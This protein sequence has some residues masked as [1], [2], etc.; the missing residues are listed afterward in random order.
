M[1]IAIVGS[2]ISGMTVAYLLDKDHDIVLYEANDYIGGHS[3]TVP[4]VVEGQS[5]PVDT[6]FMVFNTNTY[7]GLIRLL[8]RLNVKYQPTSMSFSMS[9]ERTGIEYCATSLNTIFAQR[10]NLFRPSFYRMFA[11]IFRFKRESENVLKE[12][13]YETSLMEYL[14]EHNYSRTFIDHF[15]IPMGAAIWSADPRNFGKISARLFIQFLTNHGILKA[16]DQP[17]W[18]TIPGGSQKYVE[19]LTASFR[20]RIRLSTPVTSIQRHPDHVDISDGTGHTE[21]FDHVVLAVHSDEVPG[22]LHD[23]SD[24]ERD[25]L[26]AIP[27]S[28]NRTTLHTDARLM[29][30]SRRAWASWNYRVPEE[31]SGSVLVTYNM[32]RLQHL[33]PPATLCV[34]LNG[35]DR[36][37]PSQVLFDT[38]YAHPLFSASSAKA[39]KRWEEINGQNRTSYCGAYWRYGFHEDGLQSALWVCRCF[40]RELE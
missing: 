37:D 10:R 12:E 29:P 18:L 21:Q 9:C 24:R 22:I 23:M 17:Q 36:L 30:Q 19:A 13:D 35:D 28:R 5:Y 2:G 39:Q 20:E 3:H 7:P 26:G 4:A 14:V 31:E 16:R 32:N 27:Y 8:D 6:G 15:I 38:E 40:G 11:D 1:R 34:T 25:I 33:T